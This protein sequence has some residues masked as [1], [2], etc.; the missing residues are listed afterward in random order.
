[1]N[2]RYNLLEISEFGYS[3]IDFRKNIKCFS[4]RIYLN[5]IT[6]KA[7]EKNKIVNTSSKYRFFPYKLIF[8][9]M[10][11]LLRTLSKCKTNHYNFVVILDQINFGLINVPYIYMV[12][13][14]LQNFSIKNLAIL[15]SF[16]KKEFYLFIKVS[17]RLYN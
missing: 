3:H 2:Q 11:K 9:F 1:M 12:C 6:K 15:K 14:T 4:I 10:S 7:N 16:I 13:K 5:K 8:A 17:D